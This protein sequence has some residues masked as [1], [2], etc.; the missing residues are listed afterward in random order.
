MVGIDTQN[1]AIFFSPEIRM[2]F[3]K[4][5]VFFD[6]I[7]KFPRLYRLDFFGPKILGIGGSSS[8]PC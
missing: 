1:E 6:I 8:Q 2:S 5:H 4:A 3:F 7:V